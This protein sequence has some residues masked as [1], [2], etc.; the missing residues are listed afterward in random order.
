MNKLGIE[1]KLNTTATPDMI[2]ARGYDVVLVA[3]GSEPIMPKIPGVDAK[4]VYNV[5]DIF[6]KDKELGKNVVFIGAGEFGTESALY[7]A[8]SGINV[9][10]T[11]SEREL[12]A[13]DRPHGPNTVIAAYRAMKNFTGITQATPKSIS[14]GKVTYADS[15]GSEKSVQA[16]SV[17]IYAGLRPRQDEVLK[18]NGT[19]KKATYAIGDCTGRRHIHHILPGDKAGQ[20]VSGINWFVEGDFMIEAA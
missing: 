10:V 12:V 17:V 18:F 9:T 20:R 2:K 6:G 7:L 5:V 8:R 3:I 13:N 16:D 15:S 14:G 1:I 11:T 19:A 4:N